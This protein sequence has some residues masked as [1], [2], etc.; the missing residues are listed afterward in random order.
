MR[1]TSTIELKRFVPTKL[2]L[3]YA[4]STAVFFLLLM[5]SS[6]LAA[7]NEVRLVIKDA[8]TKEDLIGVNLAFL[9]AL[10]PD[11]IGGTESEFDGSAIV[12][13]LEANDTIS[14]TYTGYETIT[15]LFKNL[16]T[17]FPGGL[18]LMNEVATVIGGGKEIIVEGA[19]KNAERVAYIPATVDIITD[20]DIRVK[21]SANSADA[22]NDIGAFVQASQAGGGSPI[23][24]GFEANK[25]LIVLDGVRMNN[26]IFRNGH[27][28]NV[29]TVD[30]SILE[31]M[32]IMYG[33]SAVMYGSDALGGVLYLKTKDPK[34]TLGGDAKEYPFES[35]LYT[36]YASAYG[37]KTVH[38][39][40]TYTGSYW[41]SVTSLTYRN[42]GFTRA[43][44]R[45]PDLDSIDIPSKWIR[46]DFVGLVNGFDV[47]VANDDPLVQVTQPGN[48]EYD[49]I[50]F[51]HKIK[52]AKGQN[53]SHTLNLQFS[54]SSNIPRYDQLTEL[55]GEFPKF[56]EWYY[57]PQRRLM[58]SFQT[59]LLKENKFFN[60]GSITTA[61]QKIDE[62]R[63]QRKRRKI[64]RSRNFED[65]YVGSFS[66]DMNKDIS[67]KNNSS[68]L[69]GLE[70]QYNYVKSTADNFVITT[71]ETLPTRLTRYP[72]G[73]SQMGTFA[74]YANYKGQNQKKTFTFLGGL[75]YTFSRVSSTF[76]PDG[77]IEWPFEDVR[78]QGGA[79]TG[80]A[81][82]SYTPKSHWNIKGSFATGFRVPNVDDYSK[83]RSKDGFI[84]IPNPDL[85]PEY[86]LNSELTIAKTFHFTEAD[87]RGRS[88]SNLNVSVTGFNTILL[89]AIIRQPLSLPNGDT[90]LLNDGD[91]E[92]ITI[93]NVNA[94]RAT[95]LGFSA[96]MKLKLKNRWLLGI[97]INDLR[98]RYTGGVSKDGLAD[99]GS[100]PLS[101]IPP[102]YGQA[103]FGY[104][105]HSSEEGKEW[106][107]F[108]AELG[109]NFNG[110]KLKEEYDPALGNSD[111][112]DEAIPEYGTP[113]WRTLNLYTA[114]GFSPTFSLNFSIENIFD[115]HY[116][117]FSS[118][119]SAPGRNFIMTLHADLPNTYKKKPE[120]PVRKGW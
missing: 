110:S 113:A 55:K 33:P 23:I 1:S 43:G 17:R 79:V 90:I 95:I 46:S 107:H 4:V 48:K 45:Y 119:I 103:S 26:A 85:K 70:Y 51:L 100:V 65:V 118:G 108:S 76:L 102:L 94:G 36:R 56:S 41:G 77:L 112:L 116:R 42:F 120:Q 20:D 86:G 93:A 24:R 37:E 91:E 47:V 32:E 12:S 21:N 97:G 81:G 68:L 5:I 92:D 63:F 73:N 60:G 67:E 34:L 69:Y 11:Y 83:I 59:K 82:F 27:L 106:K 72:N 105:W 28:Q 18:V 66:V 29:I 6:G 10:N 89:D 80:S 71:G 2:L 115:V 50:D 9:S 61:F 99:L 74:V 111:N 96:N 53:V 109:L 14:I 78:I 39:D 15:V 64:T 114:W 49:Q 98:G 87:N 40:L 62:D 88:E 54:T 8:E 117:P 104:N 52:I 3:R 84:T 13:G 101:H 22:L 30:Q 35:H 57:G 44:S 75:R 25:V 7:Q 58:L 16:D 19:T 38:L 31:R